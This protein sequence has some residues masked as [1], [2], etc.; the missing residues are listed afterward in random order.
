[1]QRNLTV[2]LLLSLAVIAIYAQVVE[3][4]FVGL[5][6]DIYVTENPP[7]LAGLTLSGIRWAVTNSHGANWIPLTWVSHMLDVE[8]F[9]LDP[10][11]HHLSN[12][13]IH[14]ANSLLL[15]GLLMRFTGNTWPSAFVSA[16]FAVHPLHV[17]SVSWIS[18]RKD[19]LSTL[20]AILCM[21]SY[22]AYCRSGAERG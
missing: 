3:F 14:L 22:A 19:V 18:E 11:G 12:I 9:G 16:V 20:F 13:L 4:E 17:E 1:M 8:L 6:D 5:D 10:A 7:V 2:G 15:F 21:W